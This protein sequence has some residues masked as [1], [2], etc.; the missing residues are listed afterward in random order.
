MKDL[1]V[2]SS[3]SVIVGLLDT[4]GKAVMRG[5]WFRGRWSSSSIVVE[6]LVGIWSESTLA[7][8]MPKA[9]VLDANP[10]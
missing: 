3:T 9:R 6:E 4:S 8:T 5:G 10:P 2:S 1:V 7:G